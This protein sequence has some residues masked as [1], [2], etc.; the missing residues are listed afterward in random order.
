SSLVGPKNVL[1][2]PNQDHDAEDFARLIP[3][4]DAMHRL[5]AT[6]QHAPTLESTLANRP[7][8]N[9]R[10]CIRTTPAPIAVAI[11]SADSEDPDFRDETFTPAPV[12][13]DGDAFVAEIEPPSGGF[14][15]FFAEALLDGPNGPYLLAT[16]VRVIARDGA[17]PARTRH[18]APS[19]AP[20]HRSGAT[21]T[22]WAR[23]SN[24]RA[25]ASV[26]FSPG[27]SST[28][29]PDPTCCRPTFA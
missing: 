6:G 23:R 17:P 22:R 21:A 12:G 16:N 25:G 10:L 4:L 5:T 19:H 28:A 15:A 27:P 13:R 24:R 20:R 1:Y 9:L 8:R 2:L 3:A 7:G 11:W 29:R 14:R 26:R 18:S